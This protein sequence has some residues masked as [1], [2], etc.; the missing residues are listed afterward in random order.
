ME[1]TPTSLILKLTHNHF[2]SDWLYRAV[3]VK[4]PRTKFTN[5]NSVFGS[6]RR[7]VKCGV[8]DIK[9]IKVF[10]AMNYFR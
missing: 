7:E 3:S 4:L 6:L 9:F 2:H 5:V 8:K 1:R 10:K